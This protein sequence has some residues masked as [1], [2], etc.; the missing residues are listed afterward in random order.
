[1]KKPADGIRLRRHHDDDYLDEILIVE[2]RE[3]L[4]SIT[5]EPRY[6]TSGLSGDEW[7]VSAILRIFNDVRVPYE[8]GFC[9]MRDAQ[10]YAP[11]FVLTEGEKIADAGAVTLKTY[12]KGHKVSSQRFPRFVDA[13]VGLPWHLIAAS[14]DG[15]WK[16]PTDEEERTHCQQ[17]GCKE[18]PS[19][20]YR[21]KK[22]QVSKCE[23]VMGTFSKEMEPWEHRHIWFCN[24]H[25][26]RGDCG[27]E[28]CDRNYE[29]ADGKGSPGK[30][31][32]SGRDVSES[33]FGGVIELGDK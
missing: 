11:W 3:T 28:D 8:R 14:E 15:R 32:V 33:A 12:R 31:P 16:M 6:K 20:I 10:K 4:L 5:V 29:A 13:G 26:R 24:R 27:L 23:S 1:M 18:K 9:S 21:L 7:R 2:G 30:E 22:Y 17:P 19:R 25:A